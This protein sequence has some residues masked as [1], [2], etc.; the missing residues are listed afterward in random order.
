MSDT[1][2]ERLPKWFAPW[3][4]WRLAGGVKSERPA[5]LPQRIPAWSWRCLQ[6]RR[7]KPVASANAGCLAR[8]FALLRN[9]RSGSEVEKTAVAATAGIGTFLFNAFE[10]D[11]VHDWSL[12]R[13]EATKRGI[14]CGEWARCY[15][16]DDI[17]RL[18]SIG[19]TRGSAVIGLNVENEAE[20]TC[21][22]PVVASELLNWPREVAIITDLRGYHDASGYHGPD[23]RTVAVRQG[24]TVGVGEAFTNENAG[25]T[26]TVLVGRLAEQGFKAAR[27]L[28]G[29]YQA[30][31][32]WSADEY[33]RAW[34]AGSFGLYTL[35][36]VSPEQIGRFTR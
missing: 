16:G 31:L 33:L 21:T 35:D 6:E 18:I 17:R 7:P 22:P 30:K 5:G 27:P 12:W 4:A 11:V 32:P 8:P 1:A 14:R 29:V 23:W 28:F 15:V 10:G 9:P 26:P 2:P 34:P 20:T 25:M 24:V 3:M 13:G 36:D 19:Q